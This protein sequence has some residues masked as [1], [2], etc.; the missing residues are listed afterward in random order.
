MGG[1]RGGLPGGCPPATHGNP[2]TPSVFPFLRSSWN[3]SETDLKMCEVTQVHVA[4]VV[5]VKE[6]TVTQTLRQNGPGHTPDKLCIVSQVD[7]TVELSIARSEPAQE[8]I[9]AG[10]LSVIPSNEPNEFA[11]I[12]DV[13][14]SGRSHVV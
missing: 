4:I 10:E 8:T 3:L 6:P 7:G 1:Q 9:D 2:G 12:I 11:R 14:A 5:E 13:C